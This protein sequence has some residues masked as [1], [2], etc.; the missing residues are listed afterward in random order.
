VLP[1]TPEKQGIPC[2]ADK[3]LPIACNGYAAK[4]QK[5]AVPL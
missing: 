3:R 5:A 4:L 1:S 2:A